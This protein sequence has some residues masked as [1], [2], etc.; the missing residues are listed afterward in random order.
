MQDD[1]W[2]EDWEQPDAADELDSDLYPCPACGSDIYEDAEQCPICGEYVIRNTNA[3]VEKPWWWILIGL[4]GILAV[5]V[6]FTL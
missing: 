3:W 2:D 5:I 1:E 4:A 6:A